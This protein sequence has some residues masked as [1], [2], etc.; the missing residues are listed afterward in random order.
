MKHVE[1]LTGDLS[2]DR[3][4]V[5]L[6]LGAVEQM[7]GGMTEQEILRS[8]VD[9]ALELT[10]GHRGFLVLADARG[11]LSVRVAR[12]AQR[13]DLPLDLRIS[14]T[15]IRHV[16]QTGQPLLT[17]PD[18][19]KSQAEERL[20]SVLAVPLRRGGV[21]VGALYVDSRAI[22]RVFTAGDQAVFETLA[23]LAVTAIERHE[24]GRRRRDLD[25]AREIQLRMAP[26]AVELPQGY[27]LAFEGQAADETSGDYHDVIPLADGT[28]ALVVGD[29][30]GHG[31]SAALYMTAVRAVLR[32]LLRVRGDPV[33]AMGELNGSLCVELPPDRFVTLFLAIVDPRVREL[34]WV[35][36]GHASVHVAADGTATPLGSTGPVLGVDPRTPIRLAGPLPLAP[37]DVVVLYTDGL[38]EA[39][40]RGKEMYGEEER[41]IPSIRTHAARAQGARPVL[42]GVL[43]DLRRHVGDAPIEDDVT[44]VVLRVL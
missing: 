19:S 24:D 17:R 32:T 36:A 12:D 39:C 26:S 5:D 8:A 10:G 43:A 34:R 37:G 33:V 15:A 14:G 13:Q 28:F 20:L 4:N 41:L 9:S 7:H 27:D 30:A 31:I 25:A 18:L 11:A 29:V 42:E 38:H 6:L 23:S 3:R 44:C 22:V 1:F 16:M 2:R 35:G 40:D 21:P